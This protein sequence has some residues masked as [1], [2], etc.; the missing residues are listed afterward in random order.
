MRSKSREGVEVK[1]STDRELY[2]ENREREK[3]SFHERKGIVNWIVM[4]VIM[5][6]RGGGFR[7]RVRCRVR[8][9]A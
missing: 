8:C 9:R 7:C 4:N 6:M 5:I 3:G 1:L 2:R